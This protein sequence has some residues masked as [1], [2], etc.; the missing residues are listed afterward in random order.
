[1]TVDAF[2]EVSHD[3]PQVFLAIVQI[4][5][6][7]ICLP[8]KSLLILEVQGFSLIFNDLILYADLF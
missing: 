8:F 7:T 1:L 3:Y 4:L 6:E 5:L 2:V